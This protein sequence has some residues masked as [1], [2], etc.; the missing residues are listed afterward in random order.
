[1]EA[2][3]IAAIVAAPDDPA[4]WSVYMD[5]LL[6]RGHP[7]RELI[8][9]AFG[10]RSNALRIADL[11]SDEEKLLSQ[12]L[13]AQMKHWRF[14]WRRGFLRAA[15][16]EPESRPDPEVFRALCADPHAGLLETVRI[17]FASDEYDTDPITGARIGRGVVTRDLG[18][19][20]AEIGLLQHLHA[21]VLRGT[22]PCS[23][24]EHPRLRALNTNAAACP[25]VL[26]GGLDVPML[27]QLTLCNIDTEL[28]TAATSCLHAPPPKLVGL[29]LETAGNPIELL[30]RCSVLRQL[31]SL[32]ITTPR[33]VDLVGDVAWLYALRDHAHAFVGIANI[34][35]HPFRA[36]LEPAA[37]EQLRG[38]L[39]RAL[40]NTE[41]D[42]YWEGL[43][44]GEPEPILDDADAVQ[45]DAGPPVDADSRNENGLI[46]AIGAWTRGRR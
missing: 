17:D 4:P 5:W 33:P 6:E 25:S 9:L 35:F 30:S 29:R 2:E 12:R 26:T 1:V 31:R 34:G 15:T 46:D 41:L 45:P 24:L 23:A 38:Q 37:A 13:V 40:P 18:D 43:V 21:L 32:W 44:A 19:I 3:L 20:A 27:E 10:D 7:R 8:Q 14:D 36:Q 42:I 28:L 22:E 39:E 11:E 16:L